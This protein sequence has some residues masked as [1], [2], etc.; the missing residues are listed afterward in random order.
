MDKKPHI[1]IIE[2][3][4][5]MRK[6]LVSWFA[7]TERWNIAGTASSLAEAKELFSS[8]TLEAD[9]VLLDIQLSDG[10]S[11]DIIPWFNREEKYTDNSPYF[12]VYSSFIDYM[13][14]KTALNY[15]VRA[16]ISKQRCESEVENILLDVL[17]GKTW[18]DEI[19]SSKFHQ[20]E[21]SIKLLS[22]REE[23]IFLLIKQRLSNKEI[24]NRLSIKRK[25][26]ENHLFM[27][28]DKT[29]LSRSDLENL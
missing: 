19:V 17:N 6:G 28:H 21:D 29:G 12:A 27:I 26:V 25:T 15:G 9:I 5:V 4:P 10:W 8:S 1:V 2:D 24:A 16:Y 23:E 20:T 22:K 3:H 11:F 13:H 14:V 7:A 18:I